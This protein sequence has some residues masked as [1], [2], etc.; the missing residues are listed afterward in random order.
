VA[1]TPYGPGRL[2]AVT[3]GLSL[4]GAGFGALAGAM[5]LITSVLLSRGADAVTD[6]IILVL[7]AMPGAIL[8]AACAPVAGWLLL[9]R[10]PLGR[11]FGGLTIGTVLGG[12]L[13]WFLPLAD[14]RITSSIV[15]GAF[16]FLLAAIV[17]R[18]RHKARTSSHHPVGAA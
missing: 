13:G 9:R 7:G 12:V 11:A 1:T 6:P 5:V 15:V 8:G 14:N 3:I 16:G 2:I 4:A 18:V 17:L 10:V